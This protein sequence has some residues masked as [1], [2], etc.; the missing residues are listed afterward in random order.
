MFKK[1]VYMLI[2]D[3]VLAAQTPMRASEPVQEQ[4][5]SYVVVET[6][7]K[8]PPTQAFMLEFPSEQVWKTCIKKLEKIDKK[9]HEKTRALLAPLFFALTKKNLTHQEKIATLDSLQRDIKLLLQRARPFAYAELKIT[10]E[11]L[12]K[13]A[14]ISTHEVYPLLDIKNS[15]GITISLEKIQKA[16]DQKK[17]FIATEKGKLPFMERELLAH[18]VAQAQQDSP[19]A[20][21]EISNKNKKKRE[22]DKESYKNRYLLKKNVEKILK[23]WIFN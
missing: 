8:A 19:I 7:K 22:E 5:E 4:K 6:E 14:G 2:F 21:K 3:L 20:T 17:A 11:S 16:L 15:E 1:Y 23:K 10:Y 12:L 9:L 18:E 13:K